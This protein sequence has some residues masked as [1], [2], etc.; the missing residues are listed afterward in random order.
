MS[1]LSE[2][3]NMTISNENDLT[4]LQEIGRIVANTLEAM[5]KALEAGM[6]TSELDQ[7]GRKLLEAAGAR[8]A[9]ELA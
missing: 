9:P 6:T 5:G 2:E 7:I 8:P 3:P 4:H 1:W